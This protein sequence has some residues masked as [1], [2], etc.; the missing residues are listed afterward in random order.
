MSKKRKCLM[1][2]TVYEYCPYCWEYERQPRWRTL[3]DRSECQDVYHIISDWLG[4][5]ITQKEAREK[6]LMMD[7]DNI[8]FNQS[9]QGNINKIM[10][11]SDEELKAVH[12]E[13]TDYDD[14]MDGI[15]NIE[16]VLK[17]DKVFDKT[18]EKKK[19]MVKIKPVSTVKPVVD[20][21]TNK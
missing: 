16:P 2:E 5:R 13:I 12:D 8:P 21:T 6:L 11:T 3:F 19:Q 15:K 14:V 20:K 1:C 17:N 18:D 10:Q 4:K 7:I 9:V